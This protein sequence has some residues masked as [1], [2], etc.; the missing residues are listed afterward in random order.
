MVAISRG[1]VGADLQAASRAESLSSRDL[2]RASLGLVDD[3]HSVPRAN[4]APRLEIA[5]H[6]AGPERRLR[7]HVVGLDVGLQG[8]GQHD[9]VPLQAK[10]VA[11][12]GAVDFLADLDDSDRRRLLRE[13]RRGAEQP[14]DRRERHDPEEP[15]HRLVP[16]CVMPA[17]VSGRP[18]TV[19]LR[20]IFVKPASPSRRLGLRSRP[21]PPPS[22]P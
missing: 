19:K 13:D 21:L 5:R 6:A 7:F 11:R 20:R 4:K 12:P 17:R 14:C 1:V 22:G 3:R 9:D 2:D 15:P 8:I 18:G 16:H 10:H